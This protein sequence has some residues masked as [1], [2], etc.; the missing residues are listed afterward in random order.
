MEEPVP[1]TVIVRCLQGT[2]SELEARQLRRWIEASPDHARI[3]ETIAA[4]WR[5]P[6]PATPEISIPATPAALVIRRSQAQASTNE[7]RVEASG[8]RKLRWVSWT[9]AAAAVALLAWGVLH[10]L[11]RATAAGSGS[12]EFVTRAGEM[13]TAR[14]PDGSFVR[15]APASKLR[16]VTTSEERNLWL[17]GRAFFAVAKDPARPFVVRT[18]GGDAVA[19][20][21]R[22][23]LRTDR[24]GLELV[25]VEGRVQLSGGRGKVEVGAGQRGRVRQGQ[26][27]SVEEVDDVYALLA[28][29]GG[30]LMFQGT[31]LAEVA[32][33]LERQFG[34]HFRFADS[35]APT[36][37]VS[38]LFTDEG[39]DEVLTSL[40]RATRVGCEVR[41]D[42][43]VVSQ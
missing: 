18:D 4:V 43:V 19:L 5:L 13:A 7:A 3:Y 21:T 33:E 36:R 8:A 37:R 2:Q 15:L 38:A 42:S 35:V 39:F 20:G 28:W 17:E 12:T 40:C 30:V 26:T 22:F 31:P 23:D 32:H 11:R 1:Y 25:V 24:S 14:L 34:V 27:P 41:N 16:V 29:P 10:Q 6:P 9:G